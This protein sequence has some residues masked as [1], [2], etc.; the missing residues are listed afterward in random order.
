MGLVIDLTINMLASWV[1]F[2]KISYFVLGPLLRIGLQA[3]ELVFDFL[4]LPRT[5]YFRMFPLV[6]KPDG[7][8]NVVLHIFSAHGLVW[9]AYV[10]WSGRPVS[11]SGIMWRFL[12]PGA[13][14]SKAL[15]MA[16]QIV[17]MWLFTAGLNAAGMYLV[18]DQTYGRP[19]YETCFS[20]RSARSKLG[21]EYGVTGCVHHNK[22][23]ETH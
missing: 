1:L 10:L 23:R 18:L 6:I 2:L 19:C 22:Q 11:G 9:L 13:R 17:Q 14:K 15:N 3:E 5:A 21:M 4:G 16:L 7:G 8:R 12:E 20:A